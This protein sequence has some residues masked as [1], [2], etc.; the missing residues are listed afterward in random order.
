MKAI[1]PSDASTLAYLA[2]FPDTEQEDLDRLL[3]P[4]SEE[5]REIANV[6]LGKNDAAAPDARER[7]EALKKW[8]VTSSSLR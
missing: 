4:L 8:A 1:P 3:T 2:E 5:S 6:L 7:A